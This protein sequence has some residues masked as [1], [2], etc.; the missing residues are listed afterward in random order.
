MP[1]AAA[2]EEQVSP[3]STMWKALQVALIPAWIGASVLMP[4]PAVVVVEGFVE[5]TKVV[6]VVVA[7]AKLT[8]MQ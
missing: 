8:W 3:P 1:A 4:F 5:V 6:D 7:P 2:M